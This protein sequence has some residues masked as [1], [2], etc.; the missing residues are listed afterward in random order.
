MPKLFFRRKA[1][2]LT[3]LQRS[4][5]VSFLTSEGAPSLPIASPSQI[6]AT[7]FLLGP[8]TCRSSASWERFRA[9]PSNHFATW[10]WSPSLR[11]LVPAPLPCELLCDAL[12]EGRGVLD[13]R[14][15]RCAVSFEVDLPI[16]PVRKLDSLFER[17]GLAEYLGLSWHEG[18]PILR[19]IEIL[20]VE[21]NHS[22]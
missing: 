13:G 15:V 4:K 14:G 9:P 10:G 12:P 16:C 5:Y 20:R 19:L 6:S 11:T 8:S 22:L 7:L 3:S 17:E 18:S 2:L 21:S 1:N